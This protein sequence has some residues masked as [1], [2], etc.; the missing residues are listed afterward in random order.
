MS[1][2]PRTDSQGYGDGRHP[3]V[4]IEFA[5]QLERELAVWK[6]EAGLLREQLAKADKA[7][8]DNISIFIDLKEQRDRLAEALGWL[9][10]AAMIHRLDAED[11]G[12]QS[13]NAL[14]EAVK[15]GDDE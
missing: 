2:T 1:D 14:L 10:G 4:P 6:H 8:A 11:E 5:R 13:V 7:L 12:I 15:G 3:Y 9:A